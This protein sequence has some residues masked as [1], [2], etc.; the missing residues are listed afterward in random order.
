MRQNRL[1]ILSVVLLLL[2]SEAIGQNPPTV[3]QEAKGSPC[4]NIVA[5]TGDVKLNC[6]S[7]TPAQQK[8]I[9]S[10]P[11][12]LRKI[13]N[14][15]LD[16]NAVVK[17]LNEMAQLDASS[18]ILLSPTSSGPLKFQL[19]SNSQAFD[20]PD[21]GEFVL[22]LAKESALTI[23]KVAGHIEVSTDIRDTSGKLVA[24][25][26]NNEWKLRPSLLWDRNYTDT[27]LEVMDDTGNVVLQ[28]VVL[29]DRIQIQGIWRSESGR[30][31]EIANDPRPEHAGGA[32]I[33]LPPLEQ[34]RSGSLIKIEPIF[35]YPSERHR[36][37]LK[38]P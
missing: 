18:G 5:L 17:K 32:R 3:T 16:A 30:C 31:T 27:A 6:S 19:G 7:L 38:Q 24:R 8:I 4:S 34:C 13:L 22:P 35:L 11:D 28:I 26:N 15:Q 37:Q 21:S 10:I 36:G 1:L 33:F 20:L 14:S 12:V 2:T 9:E 29:P 25:I 23:A